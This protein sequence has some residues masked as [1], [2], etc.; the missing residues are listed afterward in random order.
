MKRYYIIFGKVENKNKPFVYRVPLDHFEKINE[1]EIV[2]IIING[3][4]VNTS[5]FFK[6]VY[7]MVLDFQ[8]LS[9]DNLEFLNITLPKRN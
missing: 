8:Q 5:Y 2:D 6:R 1:G 4:F 3:K 9:K 7:N